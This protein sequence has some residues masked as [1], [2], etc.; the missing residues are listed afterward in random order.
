MEIDR[1]R[2]SGYFRGNIMYCSD[3]FGM[4]DQIVKERDR[5]EKIRKNSKKTYNSLQPLLTENC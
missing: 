1:I 2:G 5:K 4:L 3:E